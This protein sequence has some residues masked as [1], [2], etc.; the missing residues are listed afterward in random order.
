MRR[1]GLLSVT[2][3]GLMCAC[4][5]AL[6][7]RDLR[8][9]DAA[10]VALLMPCRAVAQQRQLV[11]AGSAVTLVLHVC[12]AGGRSWALAHADVDD[13]ARVGRA[14]EALRTAAA[15]NI[16]ATAPQGLPL[17]VAAATPQPASGRERLAGRRQDG[18]AIEMETAVFAR[19]TVVFQASVLGATVARAEADAFFA[20]LRFAT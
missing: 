5:P 10:G 14:L 4:A 20:S 2:A 13:P 6:D 16:G 12:E 3:C 8:P 17:A 18:S 1:P 15:A 11:L 7:W 9:A 19:G